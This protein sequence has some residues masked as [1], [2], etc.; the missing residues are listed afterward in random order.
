MNRTRILLVVAV[1]FMGVRAAASLVT[2]TSV[3]HDDPRPQ[4]VQVTL[5]AVRSDG[6]ASPL[7]RTIVVPG[8]ETIELADG[9]WELSVQSPA[10]WSAVSI[11]S[12]SPGQ[13]VVLELWPVA[14]LRGSITAADKG[15][16][17]RELRVRF[18]PA[19]ES[20]TGLPSGEATCALDDQQWRCLLPA[21]VHDLRIL[22]PGFIA[23]FRWNQ[24]LQPAKEVNLGRLI[25]RRGASLVGVVSV[26]RGVRTRMQDVVIEARPRT[27]TIQAPKRRY[28]TSA[29]VRGFF[30]LAGL[31]P[32]DYLI[33]AESNGADAKGLRSEDR[34][35]TIIEDKNA[36]LRSPLV[37]DWPRK[38]FLSISPPSV[39]S[40]GSGWHLRL[41]RELD[42]NGPLEGVLST[43]TD[44]NGIWSGEVLPGRYLLQVG[45][46]DDS[47]WRSAE[48]TVHREDVHLDLEVAAQKVAGSVRMGDQPIAGARL[49]FGGANGSQRHALVTDD[50]GHF[51]GDI[52]AAEKVPNKWKITIEAREPRVQRTSEYEAASDDGGHLRF[53][54]EIPGT[55]V[56]GR[57]LNEDRT[58][59][60]GA[61]VTL[62]SENG[63]VIEQA[64]AEADGRFEIF[65]FDP[66][67]VHVQAD[68]SGGASEIVEVRASETET[69]GIDL[70]LLSEVVVRGRIR[71]RSA[72]GVEA[73]LTALQRDVRT[74]FVP[75]AITDGEGRF[76]LTLPPKTRI[77]DLVVQA[78]GFA[79]ASGRVTVQDDK[80]LTI[81]VDQLGGAFDVEIPRN[82]DVVIRHDGAEFPARWLATLSGGSIQP[83]GEKWDLASLTNLEPGQ[84]S[85]CAAGL[86]R[87]GLVLPQGRT[88]L[89]LRPE[90]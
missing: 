32:G 37:L 25:L 23:E 79:L 29:N 54:I 19:V 55:V 47:V 60:P 68:G 86:C 82:A 72:A 80:A 10:L 17:I 21:G 9:T 49:I 65:G 75:N 35:A 14:V 2:V 44:S 87:T 64:S 71:S 52:P 4:P 78:P 18:A 33:H 45:P 12:V 51:A 50:R 34:P 38:I 27:L 57:V 59:A 66:G 28:T 26:A 22:S 73:K 13:S 46:S 70:V 11:V 77:F 30:Q 42:D 48:L 63:G 58:A 31:P 69:V 83:R 24:Q 81:T 36:E 85:V 7:N 16:E 8:T 3:V 84:Y 88:L 90:S 1:A 39:T 61:L 67:V 74:T 20:R 89:S 53:D 41:Y 62:R 15:L 43:V 40:A 6:G 76:E 5:R 56:K